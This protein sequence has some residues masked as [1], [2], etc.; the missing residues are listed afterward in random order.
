MLFKGWAKDNNVIH[1]RKR[2]LLVRRKNTVDE[3]LHDGRSIGKT[4]GHGAHLIK[5]IFRDE[6]CE[7]GILFRGEGNLME[8][9]IEVE[10]SEPLNSSE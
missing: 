10:D 9:R 8:G 1:V 7:F 6:G 4:K 3:A 5:S 2:V